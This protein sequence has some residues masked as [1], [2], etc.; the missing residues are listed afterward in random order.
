MGL[1]LDPAIA[2]IDRHRQ[3]PGRIGHRV[4]GKRDAPGFS[5]LAEAGSC[6]GIRKIEQALIDRGLGSR[7]DEEH[8]A[9]LAQHEL[10]DQP[11]L[12]VRQG[13]RVR[14]QQHVEVSRQRLELI[15]DLHDVERPVD[16]RQQRVA[17]LSARRRH[18]RQRGQDADTRRV[19]IVQPERPCG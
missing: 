3:G 17:A 14:D 19:R 10:V 9:A 12:P 5:Q 16:I 8:G 11:F 4:M 2:D 7:I 13:R 6:P 1:F 18:A 15:G